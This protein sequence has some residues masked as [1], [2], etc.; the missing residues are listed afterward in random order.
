MAVK[1]PQKYVKYIY[2][3]PKEKE[4]ELREELRSRNKKLKSGKAV[5]C[6]GLD[7]IT[8]IISVS[9]DVWAGTCNRQG[10]WYRQSDKNGQYLIISS[11]ELDGWEH[12]KQA[13]ITGSDFLLPK[14]ATTKD[15]EEMVRDKDFRSIVPKEWFV[16]SDLE[17]RLW[18]RWA[19]RLGSKEEWDSLFLTHTACHANFIKPRLFLDSQGQRIPYSIDKT[20]NLC[21]CCLELFQVIGA[22]WHK[23]LVA[24]CAGAAIFARLQADRYLLVEK[25]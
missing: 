16:V 15:K 4:E 6:T 18:T 24:P 23:K 7:E 11:Y 21:S 1:A 20:A 10:S 19:R 17:Q 9:P 12:Y 2:W 14:P 22:S 13:T 5:V 8:E 3:L 25:P